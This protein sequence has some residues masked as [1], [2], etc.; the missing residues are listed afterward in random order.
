MIKFNINKYLEIIFLTTLLLP[1]TALATEGRPNII[2]ILADDLGYG[3]VGVYG[4]Q[5]IKTPNLDRMA[6][7]GVYLTNFYAS[8]NVCTPSRAG[9]LTGRYPIRTGLGYK[10]ISPEH[11]HGIKQEE[12][13]LAELLKQENYQTALIGKWHLG[14]QAEHWP[15]RHG[16]DYYYGLLYSND[17]P[18][19]AL[20]RGNK[21]IEEPVKQETLTERFTGEAID[22]I[23]KNK[24]EPFFL[25][26]PHTAPHIP[27]FVSEKFSGKSAAGLYGDVV[28]TLDWSTGEILRTLKELGIDDN[29][30]VIFT[31][32]NGAWFEGSNGV[33]RD[34]KGAPWDGGFKVPLIARWPAH[35]PK[36]MHSNAL[37]MNFDIY[38]TIASILKLDNKKRPDIDGKDILPV[39]LGE[40]ESPHEALYFFNNEDISAVRTQDWKL[41]VRSYYRRIL[42]AF[43]ELDKMDGFDAP[44]WLLFNMNSKEPERYSLARE[45]PAVLKQH[46][47]Y[48]TEARKKFDSLRT[49]A[50]DDTVPK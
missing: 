29:T 9:L 14:H 48:L 34:M 44:Y 24:D 26:L 39:L 1:S 5:R 13:T 12:F 17:T 2:L 11:T 25:Y 15:T 35:I 41:L 47:R 18:P 21:K 20:Y 49:H 33:D 28:E 6:K 10:V 32:D 46:I 38:A 50:R 27:L 42:V 40:Q 23:K 19:V 22:F 4:A 45:N 16:F 31:S 36:G 7:E 37:T 3:D 30:F 8:A 43:D